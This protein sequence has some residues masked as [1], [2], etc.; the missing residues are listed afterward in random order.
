MMNPVSVEE[1]FLFGGK[2]RPT[3]RR[4][5]SGARPAMGKKLP[6]VPGQFRQQIRKFPNV[7]IQGMETFLAHGLAWICE[8]SIRL[9]RKLPT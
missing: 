9:L 2:H 4:R 7:T 5:Q 8:F 3:S 1:F 6:V